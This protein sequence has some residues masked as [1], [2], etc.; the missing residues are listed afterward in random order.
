MMKKTKTIT[1]VR[2]SWGALALLTV[3][4]VMSVSS[5]SAKERKGKTS[6]VGSQVV[7]HI[8]FSGS[9]A[10]DMVMPE[11]VDEK[12]YIYV[13]HG[14]A[15]GIS[16]VDISDP[17]KAK[18]VRTIPWPNSQVSNQMN[19]LGGIGIIRETG[20]SSV[21]TAVSKNDVVLWDLSNP[22]APKVLQKFSGVVK[23][24]ADDHN[25]IYLLNAEGLWVIS[26]PDLTPQQNDT[27]AYGG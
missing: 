9:S 13:Q 22:A 12:R 3:L 15:E 6:G 16:V 23:V 27:S 19:V 21:S 7:A 8:S 18:V 11:Q 4:L 26:E 10:V 1:S 14:R 20:A 25:F 17:G 24:L 5:A 2:F